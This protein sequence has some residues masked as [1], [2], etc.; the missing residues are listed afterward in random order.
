[1][2]FVLIIILAVFVCIYIMS[3]SRYSD[4]IKP[5]DSRRYPLKKLLPPALWLLDT[6][7]YSNKSS[8]D[9]KLLSGITEIW[10]IK[11][12]QYYLRIHWANK[13]IYFILGIII[14]LFFGL[15]IK[16]DVLYLGFCA[17]FPVV[18]F[19]IVDRELYKRIKERRREIQMTFPDFLNKLVLLINAGLTVSKAWEKVVADSSKKGALYNELATV[20]SDIRSGKSEYRAYEDFAKRCRTPEVTRAVSIILQNLRK[21]SSELV[22]ILRI[23][24]NECWEMRRNAAKILGQEASTRL[25]A[26]MMLMLIAILFI[27]GAPAVIMLRNF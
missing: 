23:H 18:L 12:S 13:I 7:G 5:L 20:M 14:S 4:F 6:I 10:G 27:V 24:A 16:P 22:S 9:R 3:K 26:P 25:L 2:G 19:Y 21:G 17:G 15:F 11:Y 1:M 8:Y